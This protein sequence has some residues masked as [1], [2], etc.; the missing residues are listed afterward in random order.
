MSGA[1]HS[2]VL[3]SY[4]TTDVPRWILHCMHSVKDWARLHGW[5]YLLMDDQFLNLPPVWVQQHCGDNIY[6]LTDVSRLIWMKQKLDE[7]YRRVI[8]ADADMLIMNA[9]GLG[10]SV[11]QC[12]GHTFTR[13]LFLQ[14][15]P[16]SGITIQ[17]GINNAF[18]L[19]ERDDPIL[20][21]YLSHILRQLEAYPPHMVPRTALGPRLVQ[22]LSHK[23]PLKALDGIGLFTP[24]MMKEIAQGQHPILDRYEAELGMPVLAANLCHFMRN[25]NPP[26]ARPLFDSLYERA[27]LQLLSRSQTPRQTNQTAKEGWFKR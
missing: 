16:D 15:Q 11:I 3:Q 12:Q 18:M 1:R 9:S 14:V 24:A 10:E 27:V 19:F 22:Q 21:I 2:I 20:P 23:Y 6:A 8:W 5:D 26:S 13:E 7:S 25:M 17:H 4:R